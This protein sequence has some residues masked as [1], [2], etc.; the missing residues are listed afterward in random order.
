MARPNRISIGIDKKYIV[1][2][3]ILK[4]DKN[5]GMKIEAASKLQALG[6]FI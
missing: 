1:C 3:W 5:I 2:I 6:S 4:C